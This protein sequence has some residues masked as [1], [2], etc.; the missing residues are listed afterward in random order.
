MCISGVP[1]D[2]ARPG[3]HPPTGAHSAPAQESL[4]LSA[5]ATDG[6][7]DPE[8]PYDPA[9]PIEYFVW[10]GE[11]LIPATP[12]QV[13]EFRAREELQRLAYAQ[14]QVRARQHD[15][16]RARRTGFL[17]RVWACLRARLRGQDAIQPP[18]T[19]PAGTPGALRF[20][21]AERSVVTRDA[22]GS[23]R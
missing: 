11:R 8:D 13:V 10:T 16:A 15:S 4:P 12:A 22:P 1:G 2:A 20:R 21:A 23:E 7:G 18:A 9:C 6:I 17:P 3:T 5:A 14:Q 19:T